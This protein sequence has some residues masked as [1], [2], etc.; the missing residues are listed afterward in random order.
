[1]QTER[2]IV[3]CS[4]PAIE[5]SVSVFDGFSLDGFSFDSFSLDGFSLDGFSLDTSQ[6]LSSLLSSSTPVS[7]RMTVCQCVYGEGVHSS[8][9]SPSSS[10]LLAAASL[11]VRT[12]WCVYCILQKPAG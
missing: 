3:V 2:Y 1:M 10:S 4:R 12:V 6:L 11:A 9:S 5:I 8:S 7:Y